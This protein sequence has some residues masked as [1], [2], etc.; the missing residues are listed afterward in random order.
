MFLHADVV[1]PFSFLLHDFKADLRIVSLFLSH[2]S[3]P[4]HSNVDWLYI[5]K[6]F[7]E[8]QRHSQEVKHSMHNI[9]YDV[10]KMN[11]CINVVITVCLIRTAALISA[12]AF[13]LCSSMN[14]TL[15]G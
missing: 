2:C 11:I 4:A 10:Y 3:C 6:A 7:G 13:L 9:Q 5:L 15:L 8:P 14:A 12:S 1:A